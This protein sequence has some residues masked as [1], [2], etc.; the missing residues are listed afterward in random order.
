MT[1]T[2]VVIDPRFLEHDTGRGHPERP[3]RIAT[4]LEWL[5]AAPQ[6]WRRLKPRHAT[7]EEIALVHDGAYVAEVERTRDR[8]WFA[9]DADTP[10]SPLSYETALLASGA[11]LTLLDEIVAGGLD[12]GFAFVRPPGHHAERAQAMGFCLFN[13]VAVGAA[14]LRR[15]HGLGRVL[16]VDWDLHHG[17]GTQHMF[18]S[19]PEVL[20]VS[21]HQYP[22]YPGTGAM[23]E[24]GRG[25]G[26]GYTVNLALPG[27]CGDAVYLDGFRRVIAPIARLYQPDFVLISAGFDAHA[28]DP[29]GGMRLTEDGFRAMTRELLAI[30][31]EHCSGRCAAI[32]E[33]GYDLQ[34]IRS[35]SA[36]VLEELSAATPAATGAAVAAEPVID[37]IVRHQ[38]RYWAI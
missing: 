28:R 27:G 17:N 38:Q 33:G 9:F 37:A 12:N 4:L 36:A 7:G 29:L 26:E 31:A 25:D 21:T 8:E 13:N 24:H 30:A 22:F 18:E 15:R 2:G 1:R 11:F 6:R 5:E 14:Y 32:L 34:A 23:A 20:F 3:Q 16:V 19:D 10:T 35:S